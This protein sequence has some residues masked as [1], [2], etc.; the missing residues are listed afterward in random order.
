MQTE[1]DKRDCINLVHAFSHFVDHHQFDK[2]VDL[3]AEDAIFERPDLTAKG[4][5]QIAAIWAGRSPETITRHIC[6]Q[7]FFTH[8]D[9][10]TAEAVTQVALYHT[11][12]D[13][14]D[15]P[16]A[17]TPVALAEFQDVFVKTDKGWKISRRVGTPVM[18]IAG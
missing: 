2:A 17:Q 11:V 16:V 13:G 4:H 18:L 1:I 10:A 3:F 7:P 14:D 12:R 8:I 15:M 9:E 5:D 6:T